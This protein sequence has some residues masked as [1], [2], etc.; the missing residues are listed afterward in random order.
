MQTLNDVHQ[1]FA[2]FFNSTTL[3]AFAY[4]VSK[5]LGEGHVCFHLNHQEEDLEG[6]PPH[7]K[8]VILNNGHEL[9]AEPQVSTKDGDRQ[10]FVL[11]NDRFYLQ[12]YF[13]YET[14]ILERIRSFVEAEKK[15]L[16]EDARQLELHKKFV[17]SLFEQPVVNEPDQLA[18][19]IENTDWQ[20]AAAISGVLNHFTIISG[21]PGTG[22][23]TTVAKILAILFTIKPALRVALAAP[24]GKAA[25]RMAETLKSASLPAGEKLK[26]KFSEL[27]PFTIHRLLGYVPDSPV[28]RHNRDNPLNYDVIIVDESSMMDVALFAKLMD[29]TGAGTRLVLLGDKDQL[30]SVEAGS[31]FG[32]LCQAQEVLNLFSTERLKLVNSFVKD[33]LRRIGGGHASTGTGHPLFQHV[34]ELRRSHRFT[35]NSGIGK[36]SRAVIRDDKDTIQSFF[37]EKR[38]EQVKIDTGY[39]QKLFENFIRGYEDFIKEKDIKAALNKLNQLR[40]LCAVREGEHGVYAMNRKIE[41]Y[42]HQKKRIRLSGE[43]YENRPVIIT[44]NYY[45]LELFNGDVGIIRPDEKGVLKAWFEDASKELKAVLPGYIASSETVF[46]MTIHKSQGSEFDKV[47]VVLPDASFVPILTRELLYTAV[48]RARS[49]I[50]LQGSEAVILSAAGACVKRSSGITARFLETKGIH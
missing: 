19:N 12:R 40:V 11:H 17:E 18:D 16:E 37:Q 30:A 39:S 27:T 24:T 23:T 49:E 7:Y 43:F 14:V 15:D 26:E 41:H 32:D 20:L 3:K 22:K 21:G 8:Q 35:G 29:A 6:F 48:T 36:F 10:P 46:A 4:A 13:A 42:L 9:A 2:E 34:I 28:F 31:L 44:R 1:Q 47:L 45:N 50:L 33:P 38:D 5:K 25:A